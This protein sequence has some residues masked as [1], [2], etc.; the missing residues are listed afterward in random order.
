MALAFHVRYRSTDRSVEGERTLTRAPIRFGRNQINDCPISHPYITDF[1]A[2]VEFVNGR[3]AVRDLGSKN[4]VF[5]ASGERLAPR[6]AFLLTPPNHDFYLSKFLQVQVLVEQR[7]EI[8][9]RSSTASGTVLG[10]REV[11]GVPDVGGAGAS[12]YAG[13]RGVGP[14]DYVP[15]DAGGAGP[16]FIYPSPMQPRSIPAP[17]QQGYPEANR[18]R[19]ASVGVATQNLASLGVEQ[20]ALIGLREIAGSLLPDVPLNTAGEVGRFVTKLHDAVEVFCRC[21]V[22][23]RE[24]YASFTSSMDLNRV[25]SQR[26]LNRSPSAARVEGARDPASLAAALLD[27]RNSDFDGPQAVE[28]MLADLMIHQTAL[29]GS[30]MHGVHALLDE[31]SPEKIEQSVAEGKGRA[32]MFG[33]NRAE[34]EAFRERYEELTNE[35]RT[36][37]LVFGSDFAAAYRDY[38][39]QRKP[40]RPDRR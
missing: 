20:V 4:G 30:L 1:H 16:A 39:T 28:G 25:A 9:V 13:G 17:P 3:L 34:W 38:V 10:S 7:A 5:T 8:R 29:I 31:L 24:G 32:R 26:A 36:F 33:G 21:L 18:P 2:E 35:T 12:Q 6:Q 11:L 27:W 19:Q 23:L 37:E 15:N 22:P 14:A 40:T